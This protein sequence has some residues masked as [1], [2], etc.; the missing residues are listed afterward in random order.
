[1]F[2][3]ALA[4]VFLREPLTLKVGAGALLITAGAILMAV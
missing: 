1:V 4:V 2:V 3:V